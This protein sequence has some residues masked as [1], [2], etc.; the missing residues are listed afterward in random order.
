MAL[1]T[2]STECSCRCLVVTEYRAAS[3]STEPIVACLQCAD[4]E[5]VLRDI[6]TISTTLKHEGSTRTSNFVLTGSVVAT[7]FLF[8]GGGSEIVTGGFGCMTMAY[9][10]LRLTHLITMIAK[11]KAFE[12]AIRDK[13]DLCGCLCTGGGHGS[14]DAMG[15]TCD[16]TF[17]NRPEDNIGNH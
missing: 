4:I 11:I 10:G 15:G 2:I 12:R 6:A 17:R 9:Q 13:P 7:S 1:Q 14:L 16:L 3:F 8:T 5:V